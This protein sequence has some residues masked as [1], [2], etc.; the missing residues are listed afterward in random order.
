VPVHEVLKPLLKHLPKSST[1]GYLLSGLNAAG[2]NERR[3]HYVGKQFGAARDSLKIVGIRFHDLGRNFT[4]A[5]ERA[6]VPESTTRL[7]VGHA[8]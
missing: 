1:D 4:E 5:L 7:L 3:G 8:R 2:A 6:Q